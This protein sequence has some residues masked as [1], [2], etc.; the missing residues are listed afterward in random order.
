[1]LNFMNNDYLTL[2]LIKT[3]IK[4]SNNNY[5]ASYD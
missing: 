2:W 4:L 1:M 3:S 5:F